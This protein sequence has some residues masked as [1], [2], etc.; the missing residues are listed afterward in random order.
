MSVIDFKPYRKKYGQ[1]ISEIDLAHLEDILR[2]FVDDF[3]PKYTTG[4]RIHGGHLWNKDIKKEKRM[5]IID[6]VAYEYTD[7]D[8]FTFEPEV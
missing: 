1:G 4:A 5:E 8:F 3:Y 2:R 6:L 7:S